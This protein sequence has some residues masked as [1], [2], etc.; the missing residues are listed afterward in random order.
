MGGYVWRNKETDPHSRKRFLCTD[1]HVYGSDAVA[2]VGE[3]PKGQP[4]S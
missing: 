1:Q 4:C 2:F 3:E